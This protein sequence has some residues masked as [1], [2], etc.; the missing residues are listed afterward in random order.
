M[1]TIQI[2][3]DFAKHEYIIAGPTYAKIATLSKN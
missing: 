2:P 1:K 3:Q